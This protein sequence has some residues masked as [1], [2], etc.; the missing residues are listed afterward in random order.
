[1]RLVYFH[2]I[3]VGLILTGSLVAIALIVTGAWQIFPL[4]HD[5]SPYISQVLGILLP[6]TAT[7]GVAALAIVFLT[8]QVIAATGK[9][10]VLRELYRASDIYILFTLLLITTIAGYVELVL[11]TNLIVTTAES[12][13]TDCLLIISVATVLMI[14]PAVISQIENLDPLV[15]AFKIINRLKPEHL[16]AYGLTEVNINDTGEV[17]Y[18]LNLVSLRPAATD[19][20]RPFHELLMESV[21]T[22]DRVL[23]GKL[24]RYL[25]RPIA[26]SYGAHWDLAGLE[27][28]SIRTNAVMGF[29]SS[30][31]A[32][33]MTLAL[34][35]YSVKRARNLLGEWHQL[36]IGRHGILTA[37]GD[38][39]YSLSL[40]E[41]TQIAIRICLYAVLH[42][43]LAYAVIAP[44]GRF[45]PMNSFFTAA[46]QLAQSGKDREAKLCIEV[47]AW[48]SVHTKQLSSERRVGIT[49]LNAE[50]LARYEANTA[51]FEAEPDLLPGVPEEDP[52]YDVY[53]PDSNARGA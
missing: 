36:D 7:F 25:L 32:V 19:P 4:T 35:H 51:L 17:S 31:N 23:F 41:S 16:L 30:T 46:E 18:K 52:W 50:L 37:I 12:R 21:K 6:T 1:M 39:I 10:Y 44:F 11:N 27:P 14:L 45:E 20:L 40:I 22:R 13:L 49:M 24:Y 3:C 28:R 8:A 29:Q 53:R 38:L 47:L 9:P 48:T 26:R 34:M 5:S 15:L 33:H 2:R 43:E 42:I